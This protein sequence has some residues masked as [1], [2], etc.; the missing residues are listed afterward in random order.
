VKASPAQAS[1]FWQAAPEQ[2]YQYLLTEV[3]RALASGSYKPP[4]LAEAAVEALKLSK[5][6]HASI[7]RIER[8]VATDPPLA[9][10]ILSLANSPFY[11]GTEVFTSL[12]AAL[13]RVGMVNMR[14][15]LAQAVLSSHVFNVAEF[16]QWMT[17]LATEA[18]GV[19][20]ACAELAKEVG[21]GENYAFM[22]GLIHD[23]GKAILLQ[24]MSRMPEGLTAPGDATLR[25][26]EAEHA[27]AGRETAKRMRLPPQ[28]IC[29]IAKHHAQELDPDDDEPALMV[30]LGRRVWH[31]AGHSRHSSDDRWPEVAP[32]NL[33]E[34]Q[35]QRVLDHVAA[36]KPR[37]AALGALL[38]GESPEAGAV[39]AA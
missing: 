3:N 27:R 22:A 32:L 28:I 4:V 30:A 26:L 8:L 17:C 36:A 10:K 20:Y 29:A 11:R 35:V 31:A 15:V 23:L 33:V 9:A 16:R 24:I 7:E 1:L 5:N 6:P 21:S 2:A 14:D 34:Y 19:A 13:I 25:L 18:A 38:E 12:R 37:L 39:R